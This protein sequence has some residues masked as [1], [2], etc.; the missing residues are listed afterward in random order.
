MLMLKQYFMLHSKSNAVLN[1]KIFNLLWSIKN[2]YAHTKDHN[3]A[4]VNDIIIAG[5]IVWDL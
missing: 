5:D 2:V 1:V 3:F 4:Y